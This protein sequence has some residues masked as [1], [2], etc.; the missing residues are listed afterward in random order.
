MTD[1]RL[2]TLYALTCVGL[3]A[4]IPVV[5]RL[6]QVARDVHQF[7]FWS[8]LLSLLAVGVLAVVSGA[9]L[10][11]RRYRLR[12][13]LQAVGLGL[14]GTYLYYLLLYRG[15][16]AGGGME[17]LIV[18]YTW[19]VFVAL[20][21]SLLLRERFGRARQMAL[22]LGFIAVVLVLSK[23]EWQGFSLSRP[24]DLAW[25]GL[26]AFFFALFSVLSKGM[27]LEPVSLILVYFLTATL[28]SLL[29][30]LLFSGFALPR[31]QTLFPLVLNGVLVNGLSYVL[32]LRALR[33]TEAS[34][35]APLIFVAPI[36]STAYL[37]LLFDEPFVPAYGAA[38][39]LIVLAGLINS[40]VPAAE[41][42]VV[43]VK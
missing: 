18:Q 3:W 20:L 32:W 40:R 25:V 39:L 17:V 4:L 9:L 24:A 38:L 29:S 35:L 28:A 34:F 33:L 21:S 43:D 26:G 2:G 14:L 7:L 23:G 8:S 36:L 16:A 31:D 41:R 5:A 19:P 15:Y 13:W 37:L 11:L 22:M 42:G 27:G 30:M 6:G 10:Q 1:R 12:H